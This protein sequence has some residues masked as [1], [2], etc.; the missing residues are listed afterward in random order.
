MLRLPLVVGHAATL[1]VGEDVKQLRLS[2]ERGAFLV[3]DEKLF[4]TDSKILGWREA[5]D[6]Q[7]WFQVKGRIRPF[8]LGWGGSATYIVG[9]ELS[10]LGYSASKSY[11]VSL[12]QFSPSLLDKVKR[13]RPTGWL[14]NSVFVDDWYGF[15]C[16]EADDV[17]IK[18]NTYRDNIIYGIDP[19][20]RSRRLII[21]ENTAYGTQKKHGIIVSREVNDSWIFNSVA[22]DNH[23]SG[24]MVDRASVNNV[25]A[26]NYSYQNHSDGITIYERGDNL[27]WGNRSV[28]NQRHGIRLRNSVNIRLYNN[29]AIDNGLTG[30]YGHI[31]GLTNTDRNIALDPFDIKVSM[32]E[33]GGKPIGNGSAPVAIDSPLSVELY[34]VEMLA[35]PKASGISL[36]GV[37]GE[38]QEEIMDMLF[39]KKQAVLIDPVETQTEL[40]D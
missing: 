33:V 32:T 26:Y 1:A 11:G 39:R 9:S 2:E 27:L 38:R 5:S 35:P 13:A 8:L 21:T 17:V 12:S 15:N 37:L 40:Q 16:Y 14:L 25:L 34:D 6:Q 24:I 30:I 28:K 4:V 29:L 20:D 22:Y 10:S 3:N 19:H 36:T 7:A 18:G 23:L 31:K